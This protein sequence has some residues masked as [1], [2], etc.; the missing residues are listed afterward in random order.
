MKKDLPV[1]IRGLVTPSEWDENGDIISVSISTFDEEEYLV[2]R[3][4]KGDGLLPFLHREMEIF[5]FVRKDGR[6]K[7]IKI[8]RYRLKSKIE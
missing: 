2:D 6:S 5:G 8:K 4:E 3:D 1:R 7:R